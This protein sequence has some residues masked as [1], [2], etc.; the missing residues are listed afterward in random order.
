MA[1]L[2][3]TVTRRECL[4]AFASA[5]MFPALRVAA[6][7]GKPMRGAFMILSTPYTAG[8]EGR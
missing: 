7:E 3:L 4:T 5:A 2:P 8:G 6:A 1:H